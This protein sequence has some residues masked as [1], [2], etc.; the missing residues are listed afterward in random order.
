[1]SDYVCP[2]CGVVNC[3]Q[4][5][6]ACARDTD[7]CELQ[8]EARVDSEEDRLATRVLE[9]G[10]ET[11]SVH[12]E[13]P[14]TRPSVVC[15]PQAQPGQKEKEEETGEAQD[16][17]QDAID[18]D[19]L[20]DM[21]HELSIGQHEA[22]R[23]RRLRAWALESHKNLK[24]QNLG[25]DPYES[26]ETEFAHLEEQLEE[27]YKQLDNLSENDNDSV[28]VAL[29]KDIG[30][31]FPRKNRLENRVLRRRTNLCLYAGG[32][33][34]LDR[35]G[36]LNHT[37][38]LVERCRSLG[39]YG[40]YLDDEIESDPEEKMAVSRVLEQ[41]KQ[42]LAMSVLMNTCINPEISLKASGIQARFICDQIEALELGECINVPLDLLPG[43]DGHAIHMTITKGINCCRF[44]IFNYGLFSDKYHQ[45]KTFENA[46][47]TEPD[48]WITPKSYLM[49]DAERRNGNLEKLMNALILKLILA[50]SH[51]EV[52]N[53][54]HVFEQLEKLH[55]D[56]HECYEDLQY[57]RPLCGQ[58][59]G[60]CVIKSHDGVVTQAF[61]QYSAT[62]DQAQQL[63]T[64]FRCF[65]EARVLKRLKS[66]GPQ[67]EHVKQCIAILEIRQDAFWE[68]RPEL[69]EKLLGV[70][71][72]PP[73]MRLCCIGSDE[74]EEG[75]F[76]KAWSSDED[77][78][79]AE[80]DSY[81][82]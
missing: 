39:A 5:C 41:A 67:D 10:R 50:N 13:D 7:Q 29:E 27:L 44:T 80:N 45:C 81:I 47:W 46:Y 3:E 49:T 77:A 82:E 20:D 25:I 40:A 36:T 52:G 51:K 18:L 79:S 4:H 69:N 26:E 6:P 78:S 35:E 59:S 61:R 30:N 68:R 15:H 64:D 28:I 63:C 2:C 12:S 22:E 73:I 8:Q 21:A 23:V 54:Y 70:S 34:G 56:P 9:L 74:F 76:A 60:N 43:P 17:V 16:K 1:M 11:A 37:T 57:L 24:T 55:F 58:P 75:L 33:V 42:S 32:L 65:E 19:D 31:V 71:E 72:D 14:S 66:L 62:V 48:V 53:P 38:F